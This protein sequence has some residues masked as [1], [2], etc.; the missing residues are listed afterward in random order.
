MHKSSVGAGI[1][2]NVYFNE[3]ISFLKFEMTAVASSLH[4]AL[5]GFILSLVL[6]RKKGRHP[7]ITQLWFHVKTFLFASPFIVA[8]NINTKRIKI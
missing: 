6:R 5:V 3:K 1:H 7:K 2:K 8:L 4:M